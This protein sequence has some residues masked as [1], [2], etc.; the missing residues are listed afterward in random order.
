LLIQYI[1]KHILASVFGVLGFLSAIVTM[2]FNT[3][4]VISVKWLIFAIFIALSAIVLL[5]GFIIEIQ[6]NSALYETNIKQLK[7]QHIK[8]T[9]EGRNIYKNLSN[10]DFDYGDVVKV[11]MLDGDNIEVSIGVGVIVH[12]QPKEKI[13][14]IEFITKDSVDSDSKEVYF[15]LKI[16]KDQIGAIIS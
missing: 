13:C 12:V 1:K 4:D 15:S 14:H 10:V 3:A 2:F 16:N 9:P 8:R 11:Y 7:L 5:V 6:G